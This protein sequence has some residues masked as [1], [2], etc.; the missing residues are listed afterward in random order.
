M[1]F[2]DS[3]VIQRTFH[4]TT[5]EMLATYLDYIKDAVWDDANVTDKANM[6]KE[7]ITALHSENQS[8]I[9]TLFRDGATV[10]LIS[11]FDDRGVDYVKIEI[12]KR[13]GS[14]LVINH[15]NIAW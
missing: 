6:A 1:K 3:Q 11:N 5:K 9:T 2:T 14:I 8:E 15:E 7:V 12:T 4:V 13:D 10:L